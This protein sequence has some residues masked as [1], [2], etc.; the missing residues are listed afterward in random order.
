MHIA[1]PGLFIQSTSYACDTCYTVL[2][3]TRWEEAVA[4]CARQRTTDGAHSLD[5]RSSTHSRHQLPPAAT[6]CLTPLP[7][8]HGLPHGGWRGRPPVVGQAFGHIQGNQV[9]GTL[10]MP[11]TAP[12]ARAAA[13][14]LHACPRPLPPLMLLCHRAALLGGVDKTPLLAGRVSTSGRLNVA[15]SLALLRRSR[16]P[17]P[18][19]ELPC[20][21]GGCAGVKTVWCCI[22]VVAFHG[23]AGCSP[24]CL[25]GCPLAL[26]LPAAD[27]WVVQRDIQFKGA[28][29]EAMY[30]Y[31]TTTPK[32][33]LEE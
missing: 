21:L 17:E 9:S 23:L 5:T 12:L 27:E 28:A 30:L 19:G 13:P 14:V 15:R 18:P 33:C 26:R 3:G 11:S 20:E 10:L 25:K 32:Q 24:L 1:A 7:L 16:M 29:G 22:G 6:N 31:N 2:S 4:R 8:Q